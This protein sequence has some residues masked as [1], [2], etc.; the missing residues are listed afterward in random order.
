MLQTFDNLEGFAIHAAGDT[1]GAVK[2]L[3]FDDKEWVVRY[4]LIETGSW[5]SSRK[6]LLSPI[7]ITGLNPEDKT[8]S[9]NITATQLKNSPPVDVENPILRHHEEDFLN[10]YAFPIYWVGADVWNNT[11]V[12]DQQVEEPVSGL[13]ESMATAN[14]GHR[15]RSCKEILRYYIQAVDGE[16]G[17]LAGLLIDDETWA[18]R[19]FIINTSNWWF[20][21]QVLIAPQWISRIND[22]EEKLHVDISRELIQSAPHYDATIPINRELELQTYQHYNRKVYW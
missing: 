20:G 11:N 16:I 1:L 18:I 17:H 21:H 13:Y 12:D 2:D 10:Y 8:L 9:V 5:L 19:Y 22:P 7:S 3:Y 4:L 15:L 6:V 14:G